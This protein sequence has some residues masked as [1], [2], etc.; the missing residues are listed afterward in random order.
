MKKKHT[1]EM[2]ELFYNF[3][4]TFEHLLKKD[5]KKSKTENQGITYPQFCVVMFSNFLEE[6][7]NLL[8][9]KKNK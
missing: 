6:G 2:F 1:E 8:T 4:G 3:C 9:I 7:K 5:Y